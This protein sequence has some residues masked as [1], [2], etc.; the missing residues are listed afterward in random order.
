[1]WVGP[2]VAL[3]AGAWVVRWALS[4]RRAAAA[5]A[6]AEPPGRDTLPEDAELARYVRRVRELAYGWPEG[7][8]PEAPS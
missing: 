8:P 6:D 7:R 4:T 1:V 2:L 5:P 3:L